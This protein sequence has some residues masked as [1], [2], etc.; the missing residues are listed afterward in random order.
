MPVDTFYH[1]QAT[2]T[3]AFP[4]LG[5][6]AVKGLRNIREQ[7]DK[8]KRYNLTNCP[9]MAGWQLQSF[10]VRRAGNQ[11]FVFENMRTDDAGCIKGMTVHTFDGDGLCVNSTPYHDALKTSGP[12]VHWQGGM[13]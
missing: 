6:Q 5:W 10:Q 13:F 3:P 1:P 8:L 2:F 11:V 7:F 12:D 4:V 9:G